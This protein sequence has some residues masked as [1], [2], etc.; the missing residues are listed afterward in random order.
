MK[1]IFLTIV[2]LLAAPLTSFAADKNSRTLA[3]AVR[4]GD[5]P[6]VRTLLQ[7]HVDVNAPEADGATALFWAVHRDDIET[8][9]LLIAGGANVNAANDYGATPVM[10]AALNGNARILELLL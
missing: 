4:D 9:R 3:Q 1:T 2:C 6:A 7:Q 5:V 10:L 8:A